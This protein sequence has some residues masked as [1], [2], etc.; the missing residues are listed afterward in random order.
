LE[1]CSGPLCVLLDQ[2]AQEALSGGVRNHIGGKYLFFPISLKLNG[3]MHEA[4][5]TRAHIH[6][7]NYFTVE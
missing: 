3:I 1:K 7:R 4:E 2:R 5:S 6:W